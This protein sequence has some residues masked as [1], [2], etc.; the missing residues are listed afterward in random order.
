MVKLSFQGC[1][2]ADGKTDGATEYYI[3]NGG[4]LYNNVVDKRGLCGFFTITDNDDNPVNIRARV[5]TREEVETGLDN[6]QLP[7]TNIQKVLEN[8]QLII[9]RDGVKYNVQGQVIK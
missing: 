3:G 8:G 4:Y 5:V 1:Y 6:N 9:I 2:S 7:N